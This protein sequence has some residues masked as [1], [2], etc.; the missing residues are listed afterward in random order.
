MAKRSKVVAVD[1]ELDRC[2]ESNISIVLGIS[3]T[4]RSIRSCSS[5]SCMVTILVPAKTIAGLLKIIVQTI[6]LIELVFDSATRTRAKGLP[7]NR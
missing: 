2:F 4:Y 3:S 5:S 6:R 1:L 7:G